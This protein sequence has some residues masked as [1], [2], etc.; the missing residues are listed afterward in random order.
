MPLFDYH[1]RSC[2]ADFELLVLGNQQPAC[3]SCRSLDIQRQVSLTAAP[4]KSQALI[5]AGRSAAAKEGHF[6]H[7]SKAERAKV[8]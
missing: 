6:S 3:K 1:C 8:R 4:G 7:Y 2:G 5:A